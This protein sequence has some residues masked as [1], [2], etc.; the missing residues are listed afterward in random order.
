MKKLLTNTLALAIVASLCACT[1]ANDGSKAVEGFLKHVDSSKISAD[2]KTEI[3]DAV[4]KL[5][6]DPYTTTDAITKGL[7][8]IH[9]DYAAAIESTMGDDLNKSIK[10]LQP[11]VDSDDKYLSADATF[12]LV[13][14]MMNQDRFDDL[15]YLTSSN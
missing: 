6:A 5:A 13:R 15:R 7:T 11:M 10:M 14:A 9:S 12:F 2:K 4:K 3:K 8:M 1:F